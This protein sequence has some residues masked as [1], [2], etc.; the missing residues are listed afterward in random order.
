M[1]ISITGTGYMVI[2]HQILV[3]T[4]PFG[5][6]HPLFGYQT[7]QNGYAVPISVIWHPLGYKTPILGYMTPF[8]SHL[9][10]VRA[11][12]IHK[13]PFWS[14]NTLLVI[15]KVKVKSK[16]FICLWAYRYWVNKFNKGRT[17]IT[18]IGFIKPRADTKKSKLNYRA[19]Y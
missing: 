18:Q 5:I 8:P 19:N 6:R 14:W 13:T 7:P 3:I 17:Q 2:R 12:W 1:T 11:C 9:G 4:H 16:T 15:F 10:Y